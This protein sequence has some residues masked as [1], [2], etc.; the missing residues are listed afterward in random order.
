[1]E[2]NTSKKNSKPTA[3]DIEI[4][5]NKVEDFK[6]FLKF[7][8]LVCWPMFLQLKDNRQLI[9]H[10]FFV[11]LVEALIWMKLKRKTSYNSIVLSFWILTSLLTT[12]SNA[13]KIYM[14]GFYSPY[15]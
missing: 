9:T 11:L 6:G 13:H 2:T 14:D 7:M 3:I 4:F 1:M 15:E 12:V 10:L 8:R 5:N